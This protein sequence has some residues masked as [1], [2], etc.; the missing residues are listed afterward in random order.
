MYY[1][2]NDCSFIHLIY[3]LFVLIYVKMTFELLNSW[4]QFCFQFF[5]FCSSFQI[6]HVTKSGDIAGPRVLEHIVDVVL[7]ME[8]GTFLNLFF[9]GKLVTLICAY[10]YSSYFLIFSIFFGFL[11]PFRYMYVFLNRMYMWWREL[12]LGGGEEST[13]RRR[14]LPFYM[15]STVLSFN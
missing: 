2:T 15:V 4:P 11:Y 10:H 14:N 8:V 7:Y 6:G 1:V 9:F 3:G 13:V 5:F 12:L